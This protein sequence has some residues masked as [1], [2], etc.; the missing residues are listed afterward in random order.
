[1]NVWV[2]MDLDEFVAVAT[3]EDAAR[4]HAEALAAT[5]LA[6]GYYGAD[7]ERRFQWS[8][9]ELQRYGVSFGRPGWHATGFGLVESPLIAFEPA[10]Q[11][12]P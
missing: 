11:V 2:I 8:G 1:M 3:T 7:A 12:K 10:S 9:H 4:T 6:E 5:K